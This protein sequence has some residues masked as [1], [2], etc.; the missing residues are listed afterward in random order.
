M[1]A[2]ARNPAAVAA[3]VQPLR[4]AR[5]GIPHRAGWRMHCPRSTGWPAGEDGAL[6]LGLADDWW[7]QPEVLGAASLEEQRLHRVLQRPFDERSEHEADAGFPPNW[8]QQV[9]VSCSS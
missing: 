5:R 6:W 8:A 3:P 1:N 4:Q 9:E 2:V 7:Q